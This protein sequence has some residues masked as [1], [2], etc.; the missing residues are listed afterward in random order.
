M[1]GGEG[2][3]GS[4]GMR[5]LPKTQQPASLLSVLDPREAMG[6]EVA[7]VSE[8]KWGTWSRDPRGPRLPQLLGP[9]GV[10]PPGWTFYSLVVR[11]DGGCWGKQVSS[12]VGPVLG[13][14]ERLENL[15]VASLWLFLE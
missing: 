15:A 9:P 5:G 13:A 1:G 12:G 10:P 6:V 3:S 8:P 14:C 7:K 4:L 2:A 11:L